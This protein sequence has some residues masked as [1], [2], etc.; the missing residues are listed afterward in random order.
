MMKLKTGNPVRRISI[1]LIILLLVA[2]GAFAQNKEMPTNYKNRPA[3]FT[4]TR[5]VITP[6]MPRFTATIGSIG[7]TM[8]RRSNGA[9]EPRRWRDRHWA[10][11]SDANR[12]YADGLSSGGRMHSGFLD[13][14]G[15]RVYRP[16]NGK[17]VLVRDDKVAQGGTVI[18]TWEHRP[19]NTVG[20]ETTTYQYAWPDSAAPGDP[21]WFCVYAIDKAGNFSEPSNAVRFVIPD[22][23]GQGKAKNK[24]FRYKEPRRSND[25]EAPASPT[26]LRGK[27]NADGTV[28]FN[29]SPVEGDDLQGYLIG[30]TITDPA[31]HR[32]N[33]L[34]LAGKASNKQEEILEGDM[35]FVDQPMVNLD[36]AHISPLFRRQEKFVNSFYPL[37]VPFDLED[38]LGEKWRLVEHGPNTPVENGGET[39]LEVSLKEGQNFVSFG[40][41]IS[42]DDQAW[43]NVPT[44][45]DYV[46]EVWLKADRPDAPP[47]TFLVDQAK[48]DV[49]EAFP[50]LQ[51]QATTEWKR[52]RKVVPSKTPKEGGIG[53]LTLSFSGPAKYSV[54]NFRV[55]RADAPFLAFPPE[56][57]ERIK[58]SG[59][60]FLRTH[61]PIKTGTDT[62][63]MAQFTNDGGAIRGINEGNTLPQLLSAI[64][65]SGAQAWLQVEMHMSPE[66]WHGF[67]EYMAAPFDPNT[68]SAD[69][70]PWAA[71]RYAQGYK[72][73]WT[74]KFDEI[75]FE[76]SNETWNWSFNP[77]VFESMTD[78]ATGQEYDRGEVYGLFNEY[79]TESLRSSPWWTD[80]V[81][82]KFSFV[83]GGWLRSNYG[84]NAAHQNE[85]ADFHTIANY[86]RGWDGARFDE[87]IASAA[88]INFFEL[89][90]YAYQGTIPTAQTNVKH[91][92]ELRKIGKDIPMGTYEAG[93]GYSFGNQQEDRAQELIGKSK[94]AGTA[95][96]DNFLMLARYGFSLHNFFT[97]SPGPRWSSHTED[98]WGGQ[99]YPSMLMCALFNHHA[100][101]DFLDIKAES[102]PTVDMPGQRRTVNVSNAP[103]ADVYATRQDDRVSVFCVSR[104]FPDFPE[105]GADGFTPMTIR[106]PF[107]SAKKV[108]LYKL[109]GAITDNNIREKNVEIESQVI[110]E[111]ASGL[112]TFT[113]NEKSGADRRGLPPGE[114]YLY[115]F[116]GTD[117]G[118][119]GRIV[120]LEEI[121]E[122]PIGFAGDK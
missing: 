95:T 88:P 41:D 107:S 83:I 50:R 23:A 6:D 61:S 77:W 87:K 85:S 108:T 98:H 56:D 106:L 12:V 119:E 86:I 37:R 4:V 116:E 113:I 68:D 32:G 93:P 102:V 49:A 112:G 62:Y 15:V 26:N 75:Y 71:K 24:T 100:T 21:V 103:L 63:S 122:R 45:A 117:I 55:Y 42:T 69:E 11:R 35:I 76:I 92:L 67:V 115:V 39:Y 5:D 109:S 46:V 52:F 81:E 2:A 47:V 44:D 84:W 90:Q 70:K 91:L 96:I 16:I 38:P 53:R 114:T 19:P 14:A 57:I 59:L 27:A 80:E 40:K 79:V 54:D 43:Y 74:E 3:E 18:E 30:F 34:Q 7:N 25:T 60:G 36:L 120:P 10:S 58:K 101:G 110:S 20:P 104:Q 99:F 89:L 13:G 111:N 9:F 97:Y 31:S 22:N 17:I 1:A 8:L 94:A 29:W 28:T 82:E 65:A 51:F 118:P 66:E 33:Y 78:G 121:L 72:E 105:A 73:P 64:H 48:Q